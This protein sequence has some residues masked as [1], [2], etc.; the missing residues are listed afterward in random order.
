MLDRLFGVLRNY[1]LTI[2]DLAKQNKLKYH[3]FW[4]QKVAVSNQENI[5]LLESLSSDYREALEKEG[6][7]DFPSLIE[8]AIDHI[9]TLKCEDLN[10]KSKNGRPEE[11]SYDYVIIDEY[12][13]ISPLE[14]YLVRNLRNLAVFKLFCVGDD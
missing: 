12:Q 13:D 6:G 9:K 3:H 1:H 7:I 10:Q 4:D 11:Y 8:M 5:S 2:Q 14:Y